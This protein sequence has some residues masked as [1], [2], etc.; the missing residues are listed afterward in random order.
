MLP[1]YSTVS[2]PLAG[3]RPGGSR[4]PYAVRE[5]ERGSYDL[6]VAEH[7]ADNLWFYHKAPVVVAFGV[8]ELDVDV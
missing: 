3:Q 5:I 2:S 8:D 7:T 6:K 1:R 4:G